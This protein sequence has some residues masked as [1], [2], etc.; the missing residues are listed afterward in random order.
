MVMILQRQH[1]Q[2]QYWTGSSLRVSL[3]IGSVLS[4]ANFNIIIDDLLT[5]LIAL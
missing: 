2:V 4:L 3:H 5:Q 1:I